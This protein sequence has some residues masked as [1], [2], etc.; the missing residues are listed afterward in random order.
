MGG[1][2]I[3]RYVL[4]NDGEP[5]FLAEIEAIDTIV[6]PDGVTADAIDFQRASD[7]FGNAGHLAIL[8]G[9]T[10]LAIALDCPDAARPTVRLAGGTDHLES[11]D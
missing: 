7:E 5:D 1:A 4:S 10:L 3:D 11:D 6:I 9:N 2:G 8:A